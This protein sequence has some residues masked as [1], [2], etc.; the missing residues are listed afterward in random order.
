MVLHLCL[1]CVYS[2]IIPEEDEGVLEENRNPGI[3]CWLRCSPKKWEKSQIIK[4]ITLI[5]D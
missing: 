4:V 2:H 3:H 1:L 5:L